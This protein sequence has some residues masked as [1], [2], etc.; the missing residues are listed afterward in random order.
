MKP[1]ISFNKKFLHN[2]PYKFLVK[3]AYLT[4][5]Q[6]RIEQY[7]PE[8]PAHYIRVKESISVNMPNLT[9]M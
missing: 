9:L 2:F 7:G 5:K 1:A 6:D 4:N 8:K 3:T